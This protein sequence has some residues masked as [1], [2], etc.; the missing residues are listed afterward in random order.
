VK[1]HGTR[2]SELPPLA[3]ITFYAILVFLEVASI[4][5]AIRQQS[6]APMYATGW[7]PVVVLASLSPAGARRCGL[8]LGRRAQQ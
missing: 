6:W 1:N 5:Q 7:L 2:L 4:V 8:R 3:L